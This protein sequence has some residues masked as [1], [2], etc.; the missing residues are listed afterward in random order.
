MLS[1]LEFA[2][3]QTIPPALITRAY[4]AREDLTLFSGPFWRC[5]S[6][7]PGPIRLDAPDAPRSFWRLVELFFNYLENRAELSQL[8]GD[9]LLEELLGLRRG[10]E[11]SFQT[12][13]LTLAVG[14]ESIAKLLSKGEPTTKLAPEILSS[15]MAH[16]E[17]WSGEDRIKER[18]K[19]SVASLADL[20]AA[21]L[22]YAWTKRTGNP[23]DLVDSW[24]KIR[25]PK[26]HGRKLNQGQVGHDL[27][28]CAIELMYRVVASAIGYDGPIMLTSLRGWISDGE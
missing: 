3:A 23:P 1:A 24:R 27:Y 19:G 10:A 2:T 6:S 15:L 8:E 4:N 14:I 7:M 28:Y 12:A 17:R 20:T 26:A 11:G 18:V 5:S 9:P 21:D 25:N 16:I 22:L 13:C